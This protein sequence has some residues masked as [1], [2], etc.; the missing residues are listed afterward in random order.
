MASPANSLPSVSPRS[1][2]LIFGTVLQHWFSCG[3]GFTQG[4][5]QDFCRCFC[6]VFSREKI[7]R[8][9][10]RNPPGGSPERPRRLP[11]R[12]Q[13]VS[14]HASGTSA[15]FGDLK[16]LTIFCFFCTFGLIL[17]PGWAPKIMQKWVRGEKVTTC[18]RFF[19]LIASR[20][21]P[22]HINWVA[23]DLCCLF[24]CDVCSPAV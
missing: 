6:N 3:C 22:G 20:I 14:R 5:A 1:L 23:G 12:S 8:N 16:V 9:A 10:S 15:R 24:S 4:V 13:N 7:L 17:G 11:E 19:Y 2:F 21:P 18:S